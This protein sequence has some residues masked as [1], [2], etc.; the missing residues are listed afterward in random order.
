MFKKFLIFLIRVG[1][2]EYLNEFKHFNPW[3]SHKG[4]VTWVP[5]VRLFTKCVIKVRIKMK[6]NIYLIKLNRK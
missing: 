5:E 2:N 3:I 4:L 6:K 1:Q